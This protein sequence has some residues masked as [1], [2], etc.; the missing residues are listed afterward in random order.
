MK[1]TA[2]VVNTARGGLIDSEALADAVRSGRIAGAALDVFE[3][4]PLP[5][6]SSL[7]GLSNLILTPHVAWYSAAAAVRVQALAANEIDRHLSGLP[8]RC[9]APGI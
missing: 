5:S 3:D 9:P 8:P 7:R 4:E 6:G 2:V 1:P